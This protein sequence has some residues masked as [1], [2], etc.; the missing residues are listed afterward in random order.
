M[1]LDLCIADAVEYRLMTIG[2]LF[3]RTLVFMGLVANRALLVSVGPLGHVARRTRSSGIFA[4]VP[5]MAIETVAVRRRIPSGEHRLHRLVALDALCCFGSECVGLVA[6]RATLVASRQLRF[7]CY[8]DFLAMAPDAE[9]RS[10]RPRAMHR[11]TLRAVAVS[12]DVCFNVLVDNSLVT[13]GTV[14][15][16]TSVGGVRTMGFVA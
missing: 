5:A 11:M 9:I 4:S 8:R 1:L 13:R 2:T 12:W 10:L 3:R 15:T 6:P 16:M 14:A 7:R